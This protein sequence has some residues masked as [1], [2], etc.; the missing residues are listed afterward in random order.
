M[1]ILKNYP[2]MIFIG[3]KTFMNQQDNKPY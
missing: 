2:F 1:K 3:S